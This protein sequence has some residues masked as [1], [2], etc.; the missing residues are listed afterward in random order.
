MAGLEVKKKRQKQKVFKSF[1][2]LSKRPILDIN[3]R[4]L[5]K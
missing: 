1:L 5:V 4:R 3:E 2:I